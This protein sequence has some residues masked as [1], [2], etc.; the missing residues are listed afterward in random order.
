[1]MPSPVWDRWV[2]YRQRAS[3]LPHTQS[4][5]KPPQARGFCY[6][7]PSVTQLTEFQSHRADVS[8]RSRSE[9]D[10]S[11][12]RAAAGASGWLG[13]RVSFL[14]TPAHHLIRER[15]NQRLQALGLTTALYGTLATIARGPTSRLPKFVGT[16]W[17]GNPRAAGVFE[18]LCACAVCAYVCLAGAG[19]MSPKRGGSGTPSLLR[20][21]RW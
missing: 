4:G 14:L 18:G 11:R 2:A 19:V 8:H 7:Q 5:Q 1:M 12:L 15:F 10:R 21:W 9:G 3:R 16:C 17:S 20:S 6:Q 13:R